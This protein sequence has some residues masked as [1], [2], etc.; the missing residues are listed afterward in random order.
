MLGAIIGDIVGSVYEFDNIKT[1]EF[2]L[3]KD[4]CFFTDDTVMTCAVALALAEY[5]ES[6]KNTDVHAALIREMRRLGRLYPDAGY[7]GRF[8][9]WLLNGHSLPYNSFG[10]GSA[11]RVS[12]AA[13][14]A[15]SLEEAEELARLSAEVTHDHPEGIKGAQATAAA[16]FLARQQLPLPDFRAYLQQNITIW[17]SRWMKSG[18][19]TDSTKPASAPCRRPSSRFWNPQA[20]RTPS[21]TPSPSA[22]TA[23]R[24][25]PSPAAS[26]RRTTAYRRRWRKR[27]SP[28]WTACCWAYTGR[29][30]HQHQDEEKPPFPAH[31]RQPL[32]FHLCNS[33]IKE[34]G[35]SNNRGIFP[36]LLSAVSSWLCCRAEAGIMVEFTRK[37]WTGDAMPGHG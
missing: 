15:G 1:K 2:D 3:F 13:W 20:L 29:G 32:L 6:G 17:A 24:W 23:T 31:H 4:S 5:M 14:L 26:P 21:A 7:G 22:G 10:N 28:I 35:R 11:M 19:A 37:R 30:D 18:T 12:P 9:V 16:I 33:I 34:N 25:Q 8:A 27:R 36:P